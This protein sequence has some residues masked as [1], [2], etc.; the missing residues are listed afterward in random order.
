MET[1]TEH[2]GSAKDA[3]EGISEMESSGWRVR[4][5]AP[6]VYSQIVQF[7]TSIRTT[8]KFF[9]VFERDI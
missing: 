1:R 6:Y 5:V 3:T 9:V 7:T 2:Y 4:Q 8:S